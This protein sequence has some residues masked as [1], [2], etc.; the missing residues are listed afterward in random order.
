MVAD[1]NKKILRSQKSYGKLDKDGFI[2]RSWMKNQGLP[3]HV[4]D[5]RPVIGICNTWSELTPCNIH[6][7]DLAE[8]VKRGVWEAGGLPLEFPAMS[9]GETQMRPTAMLFRNLLSMDVEE[10]LRG[11]PID[12]VV[13]LG[14][15]D[16]T[17]PGQLMGAASVDLPT[18]VV[19]S[20][21][22]L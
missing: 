22:M 15:C 8:A 4:F 7:R 2:H 11:N 9:L 13:L 12:G 6:L 1:S 19:S 20:G 18:M 16:K 10:S 5:G 3:H 21:P 17:T 14:G